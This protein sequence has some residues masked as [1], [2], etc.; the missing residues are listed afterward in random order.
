MAEACVEHGAVV[1][2]ASSQQSKVNETIKRLNTSYPDKSANVTGYMCDLAA[3]NAES[4][5]RAL[6]ESATDQGRHKLDHL[7]HTAGDSVGMLPPLS[8]IT[9][10]KVMARLPVRLIGSI[11]LAKLAPQYMNLSSG[12]SITLT[13][14]ITTDRPVPG[15]ILGSALGAA[16]QGLTRALAVE[17][18]PM[19]VN[20]V[21]PGAV[22]TELFNVFTG[23]DP[24]RLKRLT[25]MWAQKTLVGQIGR[26]EQVA[27]AYVYCMKDAF[28]TGQLIK[29]EGGCVLA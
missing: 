20:C 6:L 18:K 13:S 27:E 12:S 24:E 19:R 2:V 5:I 9:A 29:T 23:G 8:E 17:L 26:P 11:L 4:N 28:V 14:G 22:L 25:D 1:T 10:E 21:V 3:A 15:F 7:V 16:I